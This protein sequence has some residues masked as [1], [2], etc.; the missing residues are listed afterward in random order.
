MLLCFYFSVLSVPSVVIPSLI[1]FLYFHAFMFVICIF[2]RVLRASAVHLFSFSIHVSPFSVH[3]FFAFFVSR[4]TFFFIIRFSHPC[5]LCNPWFLPFL[6]TLN[7]QLST[8]VRIRLI[9]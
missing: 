8:A 7:L 6:F 3:V 2:L 4:F 9:C 5:N 1:L